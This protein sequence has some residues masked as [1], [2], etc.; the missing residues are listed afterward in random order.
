MFSLQKYREI[1]VVFLN[2]EMI[3]PR[4]EASTLVNIEST[5]A[6]TI[7]TKRQLMPCLEY[8]SKW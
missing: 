3:T 7:T 2:A 4:K 6:L 1:D 5:R 8:I